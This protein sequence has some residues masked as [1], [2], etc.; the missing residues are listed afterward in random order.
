M[1]V[2]IMDSQF[3]SFNWIVVIHFNF[4][5]NLIILTCIFIVFRKSRKIKKSEKNWKKSWKIKN[6]KKNIKKKFKVQ[7]K[8]ERSIVVEFFSEVG[9]NILKIP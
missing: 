3:K 2:I 6:L 7:R 4:M 9:E 1:R 8:N 5:F